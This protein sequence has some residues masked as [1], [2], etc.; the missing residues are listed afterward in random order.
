M[1]TTDS[2]LLP[3]ILASIFYAR[4]RTPHGKN[5]N[6]PPENA[7]KLYIKDSDPVNLSQYEDSAKLLAYGNVNL[8]VSNGI[9]SYFSLKNHE[10][11]HQLN[12]LLIPP[13]KTYKI[14]LSDGTEVTLN[15]MSELQFPFT[16]PGDKRE[17]YINGEAYFKVARDE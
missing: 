6:Q 13:T 16:F 17:V 2:L 11:S 10:V 1:V 3:L 15:S 12:T 14:I 5:A 9:L 7:V 4:Y 8:K